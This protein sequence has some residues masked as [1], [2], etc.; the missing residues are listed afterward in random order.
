MTKISDVKRAELV[1]AGK[2]D[3]EGNLK[4]VDRTILPFQTVETVNESK[5]DRDKTQRDLFTKQ[6]Q[7]SNWRNMLV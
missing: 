2:Y 5:A 3:P 4:P 1:W 6:A 7:D